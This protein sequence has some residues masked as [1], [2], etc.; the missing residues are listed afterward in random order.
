LK[1]RIKTFADIPLNKSLKN[2][3]NKMHP[4]FF[5]SQN[6][7]RGW[8]NKNYETETELMVGFHKVGSGRTSMTWPESVDQALCF[9]WIDG[10]RKSIDAESY[11]I[12]FTPRRASS[13]WSAVN[14][15]KVEDLIKRGLMLP[16]GLASFEKRTESKSAVYAFENDMLELRNDLKEIFSANTKPGSFFKGRR[17]PTKRRVITG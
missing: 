12:R 9:G 13:I 11:S 17:P 15:K 6:D 2:K 7:F 4:A 3:D 1:Q 5:E 14:I 16:A 8:L 10:V